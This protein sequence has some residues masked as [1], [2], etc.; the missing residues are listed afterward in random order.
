MIT[1]RGPK[2]RGEYVPYAI[3]CTKCYRLVRM[4]SYKFGID[5][6]TECLCKPKSNKR[7]DKGKGIYAV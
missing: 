3:T 6:G 2:E 7:S 5:F 4:W 1:F